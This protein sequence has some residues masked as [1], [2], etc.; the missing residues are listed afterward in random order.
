MDDFKRE[1]E[2]AKEEGL[3]KT[4]LNFDKMI[5]PSIIK[6]IFYISLGL[7][8]LVGL[9]MIIT[10]IGSSYGGGAQVFGG[11]LFLIFSPILA[12]V[13]CELLVIVFKIHEVLVDIKNK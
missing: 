12:R 13:Q 8:A 2:D 7:I 10:G 11:I 3:V 5:T 1:F 9:G 6:I 4:F